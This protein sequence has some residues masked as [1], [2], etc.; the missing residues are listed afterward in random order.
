MWVESARQVTSAD[1][2]QRCV[3]SM[4]MSV[5][6]IRVLMAVAQSRVGKRWRNRHPTLFLTSGKALRVHPSVGFLATCS[7]VACSVLKCLSAHG[8]LRVF[9][10]NFASA[11][12]ASAERV[13]FP[14]VLLT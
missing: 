14:F 11:F 13:M 8:L 10:V 4:Q 6:A 7:W 5:T 1:G 3:L 12:S 2:G 9:I